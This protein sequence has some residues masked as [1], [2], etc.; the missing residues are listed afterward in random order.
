M[1]LIFSQRTDM[2]KKALCLFLSF[3]ICLSLTAC[4]PPSPTPADGVTV[5]DALGNSATLKKDSRIAFCYASFAACWMLAGGTPVAVTQDAIEEHG[6][7]VGA[8]VAI[9]GTVKSI[10]E[11]RLIAA[12]PDYVVLSADLTQHLSLNEKLT[13]LGIPHGYF[14]TDTFADYKAL[15]AQ[16]TAVTARADLFQLHVLDVEA[17]IAGILGKLPT[18][19]DKTVLLMRAYSGGIKAKRDD[20]LAGQILKE[21]GLFNIAD[22]TPSLL[23]ALGMEEIIESDPDYI[24]VLT[25]GNEEGARAYLESNIEQNPA[26]AG[27]TAVKNGNYHILPKELF[28]YKPNEKWDL[29]YAYLA[30]I[31][32]PQIFKQ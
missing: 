29:S 20:N 14:R 32:Y 21:Y 1:Q 26:F 12:T 3:L 7:A 13:A 17:R 28:H 4:S 11:E 27:L 9:I 22:E 8:D 19:S 25:M 15:M 24:F 6:L 23:E 10:D 5:T 30:D 16:L 31:I 2:T 18:E